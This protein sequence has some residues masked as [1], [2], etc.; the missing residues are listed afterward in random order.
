M[1]GGLS[2][3]EGDKASEHGEG[4][5]WQLRGGCGQA[6]RGPMRTFSR[7]VKARLQQP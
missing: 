6:R 3:D 1:R 2:L 4:A 5:Q 7:D